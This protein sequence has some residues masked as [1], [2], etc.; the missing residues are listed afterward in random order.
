MLLT[1]IETIL[2]LMLKKN[3]T[4]KYKIIDLHLFKIPINIEYMRWAQAWMFLALTEVLIALHHH[5][6]TQ[7]SSTNQNITD[8]QS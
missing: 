4:F 5:E 8:N 7:N 3:G 2:D 1:S 6:Q